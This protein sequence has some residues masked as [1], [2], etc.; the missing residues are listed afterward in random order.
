MFD[1]DVP[2]SDH[3]SLRTGVE[4]SRTTNVREGLGGAAA[5]E[6]GG[7]TTRADGVASRDTQR[8]QSK[9]KER[10]GRG[11]VAVVYNPA[12]ASMTPAV[13][14]VV[15]RAVAAAGYAG[16]LWLATSESEPGAAQ[17]R[18]AVGSGARLVIAAGGDGTARGVAAGL[19]GTGV[20]M[21]ILPVGTANLAARNLGLPVGNL[22]ELLR[23]AL[24]GEARP[25]DLAWVRSWDEPG[26]RVPA[27]PGG[28]AQPT[29]G[30]EHACLVVTG[31]GFDAGLV[32]STRPSL[33]RHLKWG[34]YALAAL[35][36]LNAPR[37]RMRVSTEG[38]SRVEELT[39]RCLLIANGGRLPA[40]IV[41][42]PDATLDDGQLDIAA[43]DI[44]GGLAG[45]ASLARQVLPPFPA[46]YSNPRL[47]LGKVR[48]RST[49][50]VCVELEE[51]APVE[52]DGDLL[53]PTRRVQVRV[54]PGAIL[55]KQP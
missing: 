39:A 35:E 46:Y 27:P 16:P 1:D 41:L 21:A 37:L 11:L 5:S 54:Q 51:P 15:D 53:P 6:A 48:L 4:S 55:I 25:T 2:A 3:P 31:I 13:R 22:A 20:P 14:T 7:V 38:G 18:L 52:V 45:W 47:A 8:E 30:P 12:K 28:W 50:S 32:A 34:A 19:A 23:I 40:G 10:A 44:V 36:N 26:A 33:K 43:I 49:R 17:A 24:E 42:I 29:L 9:R